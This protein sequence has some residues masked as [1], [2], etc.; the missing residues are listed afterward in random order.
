MLA[1]SFPGKLVRSES[2]VYDLTNSSK[3]WTLNELVTKLPA[4]LSESVPENIKTAAEEKSADII[5]SLG[6]DL[7]D[8]YNVEEGTIDDLNNQRDEQY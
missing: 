4:A 5:V 6:K 2:V 7:V 3:P 8:I 1:L